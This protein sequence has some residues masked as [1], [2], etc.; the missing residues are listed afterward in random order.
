MEYNA[1]VTEPE[2]KM[3]IRAVIH[4]GDLEIDD[5]GFYG[6]TLDVAYRFLENAKLKK[7]LREEPTCRSFS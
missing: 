2:L 7:I 3:R 4:S 1:S 5:R 6:E